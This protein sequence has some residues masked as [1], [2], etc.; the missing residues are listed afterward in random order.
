MKE[1]EFSYAVRVAQTGL[2]SVKLPSH[3]VAV[4]V[5]EKLNLPMPA[6][7]AQCEVNATATDETKGDH[8]VNIDF[9]YL[10]RVQDAPVILKMPVK[11]EA[12]D[13][14]DEPTD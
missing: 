13:D 2:M 6:R 5:A 8:M 7:N 1:T 4:L 11:T 3:L 10:T 9:E 14:S 12:G